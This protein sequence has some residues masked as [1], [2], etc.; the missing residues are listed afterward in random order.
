MSSSTEITQVS[1]VST[2]AFDFLLSC[3]N[4]LIQKKLTSD[5]MHKTSLT[6]LTVAYSPFPESAFLLSCCFIPPL[7][8]SAL[9]SMRNSGTVISGPYILT[10]DNVLKMGA[11]AQY[12]QLN[13]IQTVQGE[14][15]NSEQP[16]KNLNLKN[17]IRSSKSN[18]FPMSAQETLVHSFSRHRWLHLACCLGLFQIFSHTHSTQYLRIG[19]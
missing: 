19:S 1:H 6:S 14:K 18:H 2:T 12:K 16:K 10:S 8:L 5:L 17:K 4:F 7:S 13:L 9:H 3:S 15:Q 11:Y